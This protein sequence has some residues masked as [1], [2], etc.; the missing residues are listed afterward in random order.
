MLAK[1]L[2]RGQLAEFTARERERGEAGGAR[3]PTGCQVWEQD[4]SYLLSQ[5]SRAHESGLLGPRH[6]PGPA[7]RGSA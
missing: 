4:I 6:S 5:A 1:A 2:S 7:E 3:L